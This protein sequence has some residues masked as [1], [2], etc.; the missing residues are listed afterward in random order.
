MAEVSLIDGS[1][2]LLFPDIVYNRPISAI[3]QPSI[4]II[5]GS[6]HQL[7][8]LS[9]CYEVTTELGL[10]THLLLPKELHKLPLPFADQQFL[11]L[12]TTKASL[13]NDLEILS[14]LNDDVNLIIFG[15]DSQFS[16]PMLALAENFFNHTTK[17]IIFTESLLKLLKIKPPIL[18]SKLCIGLL[19]TGSLV[20][21]ANLARL[22]IHIQPD[23]GLFNKLDIIQAVAEHYGAHIIHYDSE[24]LLFYD[25]KQIGKAGLINVSSD[26]LGS[27]IGHLLGIFGWILASHKENLDQFLAKCLTAGY[28]FKQAVAMSQ[29]RDQTDAALAHTIKQ[30]IAQATF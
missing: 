22:P 18:N 7:K 29:S 6:V 5:G 17:P 3:Y 19:N 25:P 21:L 28:I 8:S 20:K 24:Q 2:K 26:S 12:E 16:S 23:R 30:T 15:V 27:Y 13:V 9:D 14:Q 10:T 1:S 11:N 4:G